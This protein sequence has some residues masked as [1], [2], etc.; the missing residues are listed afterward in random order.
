MDLKNLVKN[1]RS[2]RR[3]DEKFTITRETLVE[4]IGLARFAASG[5]NAQPLKYFLSND[6]D[7]NEQI[8]FMNPGSLH[9]VVVYWIFIHSAMKNHTVLNY[10]V[11]MLIRYGFLT[12][13]HS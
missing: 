1:N 10:L 9:C 7:L 6:R 4:L 3:F 2:Y 5:R 12:R 8:L 13:K 11:T